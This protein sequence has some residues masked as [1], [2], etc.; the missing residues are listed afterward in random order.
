MSRPRGPCTA[1]QSKS[2]SP[3]LTPMPLRYK[4]EVFR[5]ERKEK[6][7]M[8]ILTNTTTEPTHKI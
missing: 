1:G 6:D 8:N 3:F 4:T 2:E 7:S 5:S